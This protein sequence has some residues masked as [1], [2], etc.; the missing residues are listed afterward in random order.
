MLTNV[1][2][3]PALFAANMAQYW[4]FPIRAM[5]RRRDRWDDVDV[6]VTD[7]ERPGS[8]MNNVTLLRPLTAA[9][10]AVTAERSL[11][12]FGSPAPRQFSINSFFAEVNFAPHDF[13]LDDRL[14]AMY[15]PAGGAAPTPP[16]ELSIAEVTDGGSLHEFEQVFVDGFPLSD[17]QPYAPDKLFD[18]RI[19]GDD[20]LRLFVGRVDDRPV[21]C[22][23]AF[24]DAGL[25]AVFNI[26][27]LPQVRGRGYGTAL[28]WAA[29]LADPAL[30]A[31]LQATTSGQAIYHRMGYESVAE[32]L[33]WRP[34]NIADVHR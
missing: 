29:T 25:L 6:A 15:R 14:P 2:D 28:A 20:R 30:P 5:G 1:E 33:I 27:T 11:K 32:L 7:G 9:E 26:A 31:T 19:L 17:F 13:F 18:E 8:L 12:F 23:T 34:S 21:S 3:L 4:D 16:S 22:S 10:A 24:I